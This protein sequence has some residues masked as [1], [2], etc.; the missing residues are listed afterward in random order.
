MQPMVVHILEVDQDAIEELESVIR[1]RTL[2]LIEAAVDCTAKTWD[3]SPG[4][5][6]V[7]CCAP[8]KTS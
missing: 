7:L 6:N 1:R 8:S 5:Y 3:A 4:S 2:H